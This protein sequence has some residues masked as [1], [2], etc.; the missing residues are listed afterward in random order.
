MAATNVK[1]ECPK[2]AGT[3]EVEFKHVA[4]GVCFMCEGTG[5]L[6]EVSAEE[7]REWLKGVQRYNWDSRHAPY[8]VTRDVD[9]GYPTY[10]Y[11]LAEAADYTLKC[12]KHP[13]NG[14]V[15]LLHRTGEVVTRGEVRAAG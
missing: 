1:L 9:D 8:M 10:F 3:G 15:A 11:N 14:A 4:N 7:V 6:G 5:N 2:C 12:R 13:E